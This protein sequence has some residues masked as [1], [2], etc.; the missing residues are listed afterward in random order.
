MTTRRPPSGR[1]TAR[2]TT[3]ATGRAA[4]RPAASAAAVPT[5]RMR[6]G[7]PAFR[8]RVGFVFIVMILSLFAARLVQLQG[9]DPGQYAQMAAAEGKISVVL[10]A[11]RG[12]IVDRNGEPLAD[13]IDG[14]MIVADPSLTTKKAPQLASFLA[15]ELDLDY[16]TVVE[17]GRA[18]CR[19]RVLYTV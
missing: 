14:L 10:P 5:G 4:R 2:S 8:L 18:S 3:R 15:H 7:S 16:L 19:E 6:R 13:S 1:S 11:E 12:D 9:V 17:I